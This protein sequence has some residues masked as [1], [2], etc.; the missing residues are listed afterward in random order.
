LV[1]PTVRKSFRQAKIAL[2]HDWLNQL[3]GAEL[4]LE[5]LVE[6]FPGAPIFTTM[7][8]REGMPERYRSWDVRPTWLDRAPGIYRHHQVYLLLYPFAVRSMDVRGYDLVISNKSGF[9]HGVRTERDQLH[10]DYCLTPTRYVWDYDTYISRE[11][12]GVVARV[13]L[14]PLIRWLRTWDRRAAD[15]VD[16]FVAISRE[17]QQRI[18]RYYARDSVIIYPPVRTE[19][20]RPSEA[21]PGDYYLVVS[22]LVPYKRIDLAVRAFTRLR[23]QLIVVGDGRD[24]ATLQRL[25][26]PTVHFTGRLSERE[27]ADLLAHCKA[28]VFPGCEDFGIAPVEAQAAGRPVIAYAGGGALDTIIDGETGVLFPEQTVESLIEAV[29]RLDAMRFDPVH[30]NRHAQRFGVERFKQELLAFVARCWE[31]FHAPV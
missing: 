18:A 6:M 28:F 22:R 7:Y 26:G 13:A 20:Y 27:V 12:I 19:R 24:R 15:G 3:G 9:C 21:P 16:H 31:S 5:T 1:V 10:I 2:V 17:V 30:L 29:H 25:A 11:E 8:W 23:R 4:V 14:R